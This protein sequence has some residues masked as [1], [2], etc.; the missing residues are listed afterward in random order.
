MKGLKNCVPP[1]RKTAAFFAARSVPGF[2]L[3]LKRMHA[4]PPRSSAKSTSRERILGGPE[5]RDRRPSRELSRR[6]QRELC[7]VLQRYPSSGLTGAA[8]AHK[9]ADQDDE[10]P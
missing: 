3:A 6:Y 4:G 5:D 7:S 2:S 1:S 8:P 10:E 9:P